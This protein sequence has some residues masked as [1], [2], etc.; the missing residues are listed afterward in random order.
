MT[1][2]ELEAELRARLAREYQLVREAEHC[3]SD[4]V[5]AL[6]TENAAV[7]DFLQ[8]QLS[9]VPASA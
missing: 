7:I 1:R 2:Q 3:D 8:Q 5:E 4:A 9:T 6:I